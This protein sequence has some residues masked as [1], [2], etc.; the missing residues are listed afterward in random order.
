[1]YIFHLLALGLLISVRV[2]LAAHAQAV[3][4]PIVKCPPEQVQS[5][6]WFKSPFLNPA[7][8]QQLSAYI[9]GLNVADIIPPREFRGL[10]QHDLIMVDAN[11]VQRRVPLRLPCGFDVYPHTERSARPKNPPESEF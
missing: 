3:A 10:Q 9:D 2:P 5:P 7:A 6:L 8:S 4:G 1:M 11:G